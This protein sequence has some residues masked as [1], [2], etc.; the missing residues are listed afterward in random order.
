LLHE[1]LVVLLLLLL[2]LLML[3]LM[4]SLLLLGS[5]RCCRHGSSI[6]G[7]LQQGQLLLG[8]SLAALALDVLAEQDG[9]G[10]LHSEVEEESEE[11]GKI[12]YNV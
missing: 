4:L 11:F 8:L 6:L 5:G 12:N 7:S 1:E 9:S 10:V 2:L 3:L